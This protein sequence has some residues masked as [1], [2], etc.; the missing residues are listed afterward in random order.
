MPQPK[1]RPASPS[2]RRNRLRAER[3]RLVRSKSTLHWS[4]ELLDRLRIIRLPHARINGYVEMFLDPDQPMDMKLVIQSGRTTL[5]QAKTFV[6]KESGK[7]ELWIEQLQGIKIHKVFPR[8]PGE[9]T[10][11]EYLEHAGE[12]WGETLVREIVRGAYYCGF[13]GVRFRDEQTLKDYKKP[14][15]G[16]TTKQQKRVERDKIRNRMRAL[17]KKAR[18]AGQFTQKMENYYVR[19]FP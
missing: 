13:D 2:E 9:V 15:I 17:Y 5:G 16:G 1:H 4:D 14:V 6:R 19:A 18:K 11:Q 7:I 12:S 10:Q 8:L 3:R